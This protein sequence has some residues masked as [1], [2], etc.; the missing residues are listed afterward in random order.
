MWSGFSFLPELS[1]TQTYHSPHWKRFS[2]STAYNTKS[3]HTKKARSVRP[4][5][6]LL[7]RPHVYPTFSPSATSCSIKH[8]ILVWQTLPIIQASHSSDVPSLPRTSHSFPPNSAKESWFL[9][10]FCL[11][12][13]L[14]YVAAAEYMLQFQGLKTPPELCDLW[15]VI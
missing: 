1:K 11:L 10:F 14:T 2:C 3:Q 5:S 9:F 4:L 6:H 13:F 15:Q 12:C 8:F 7:P